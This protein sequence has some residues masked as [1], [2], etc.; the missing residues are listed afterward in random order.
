[1][2][3]MNKYA[4]IPRIL[5]FACLIVCAPTLFAQFEPDSAQVLTSFPQLADGGPRSAQW[6]T[7]FLF[8]NPSQNS[9]VLV[10]LLTFSDSGGPLMMNLGDGSFADRTF[11]IAPQ[12]SRLL[13][14]TAASPAT[15]TGWAVAESTIP[16]QATV[17]FT[18]TSN[19][20]ATLQASA[21]GTLPTIKYW[22]PANR[23]LGI[24]LANIYG[25]AITVNVI[26]LDSTGSTVAVVPVTLGPSAHTSFNLSQ[27]VATLGDSFFG[28]I[29]IEP[30]I[31]NYE[32][33]AWT[34][35]VDSGLIS[36]LPTGNMRWPI[37]HYER[38]LM[39]YAKVLDGAHQL[40]SVIGTDLQAPPP[41][42]T[43]SPDPVINAFAAGSGTVQINLAL[44]ELISD[45]PSELAFAVGHELGHIVQNRT[46]HVGSR[47]F[48]NT[49]I[50][51]DAD[52][53]GMFFSLAAGFDPY[54]AAGT[55]AK[56][57]MATGQAGLVAQLFDNFSGD[58]HGSFNERLAAVYGTIVTL[59]QLPQAASFCA[60]YRS[61]IHPHFP[62]SVPLAE[63]RPSR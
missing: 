21:P 35:N 36:S 28:S 54:A 56:L 1:M 16:I 14:S 41:Q 55:L 45:S 19:G 17:L 6:Q 43:I 12:G 29:R 60:N 34:L 57:S 24:A 5:A 8:V 22:S 32:F 18:L 49:N 2:L 58:L 47:A 3:A 62:G 26:V 33:L 39:V 48:F 30:Q 52:E 44:S 37:S 40:A 46:N 50:E 51:F 10:R 59:C 9:S 31:A 7:S 38:I 27:R 42:L 4:A 15:V 53:Y 61:I 25:V 11:T 20:T 23:N 63:P 13:R